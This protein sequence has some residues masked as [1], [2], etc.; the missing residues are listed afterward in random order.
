MS[1]SS[2]HLYSLRQDPSASHQVPFTALR[3]QRHVFSRETM[4]EF[5]PVFRWFRPVLLST[6]QHPAQ[7]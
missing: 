7:R 1:I 6:E 4:H 3:A 5:P 2:E